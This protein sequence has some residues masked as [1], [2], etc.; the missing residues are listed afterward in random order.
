MLQLLKAFIMI[1]LGFSLA[2]IDWE[3]FFRNLVPKL[4][5]IRNMPYFFA[6][7]ALA[8]F[9]YYILVYIPSVALVDSIHRRQD[10]AMSNEQ[11]VVTKEVSLRQ[12]VER[13]ASWPLAYKKVVKKE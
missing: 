4:E 7:V 11:G 2:Y 10:Q 6:A 3:Q 1:M 9:S 5:N 13:R 12:V 8:A